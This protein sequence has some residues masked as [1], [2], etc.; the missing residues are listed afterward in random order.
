[1]HIIVTG[2]TGFIGEALVE[3]LLQ[4]GHSVTVLTRNRDRARRTLPPS[5]TCVEWNPGV[6]GT[7]EKAFERVDGVVNLAGASIAA[8]RWTASRKRLIR[9]SRLRATSAVVEA[10]GRQA[11][12]PC[13][14]VTASG[15]G[16]YGPRNGQP[17]VEE[18]NAGSGFLADLCV[19]WEREALRAEQ[20]GARVVRLRFGMVLERDGGA[21]P[22]MVR[23]FRLFVGGPVQPGTQ[24]VSWIHRRD[25]IG[26]IHWALT[27]E[28]VT[29]AVNA[30]APEPVTMHEFCDHLGSVLHRPSW[31]PVPQFV[32]HTALGEM[33]TLMTTGQRVLPQAARQGGYAFQYPELKPALQAI[34]S[35]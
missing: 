33:A 32:L 30:V 8:G 19:E 20:F 11:S 24:W 31:L 5:A 16:Y 23:P 4:E 34:F 22:N 7:W 13:V 15:V 21:L 14:L 26:L 10:L 1:M 12:K 27:N 28:Q 6:P 18:E 35:G 25:I 17:V 2:G 3:H 9:N 29:G